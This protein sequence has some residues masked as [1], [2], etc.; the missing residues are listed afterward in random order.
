MNQHSLFLFTLPVRGR[1]GFASLISIMLLTC[2]IAGAGLVRAQQPAWSTTGGLSTARSL[3]TATPLTNGKV[4]VVGGINVINPCCTNTGNAELYDPATG[5]WSAAINPSTP[6]ANHVAVR[7]HNGKVLIASGNGSPFGNILDSAEIYDPVTGNWS[8]AG[9]L[10]VAR[11]SPRATLLADGR[12]LVTG[13]VAV[14]GGTAI[15]TNTAEVYDPATNVWTP[16][17]P[18]NSARVLHTVN[19]LPNGKAL[20]AGGSAASF[21]PILQRTTEIYDPATNNWTLTGELT[22]PRLTHTTILLSNGKV[23]V[24]GGSNDSSGTIIA[25]AELYDPA[26][27]QWSAINNMT[28]PRVIHT[29]TL[30]PNGK[31]LAVGGASANTGG[32]L[33]SSELYDPATGNWTVSADLGAGRQNHTATLLFNGMV[34]ATAGSGAGQLTSAELYHGGAS[35]IASISAASFT[36]GS[37]P[38]SI[39]AAFGG[40]NLATSTQ[41]AS[42]VPLPTTLAGVSVRVRDGAGVERLAPLFFVSPGQINYQVPP[43]TTAGQCLVTVVRDDNP[44]AVGVIEIVKVAPGLFSA[45]AS[46]QGVA[47]AVALRIKADGTQS[48]EPV[49]QFDQALNRFVALPVDLGAETDQV[50]LLLFGTGIKFHSGLSYVSSAIG[51]INSEVLYAGAAPGF[52]GLDQVNVRLSHSLAGRGEVDVV[53][54]VEGQIANK[55][56]VS[57][58]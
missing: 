54:T 36:L 45:N 31:V 50:F 37:A 47:A 2:L 42:S 34:L 39:V 27:G 52:A 40:V 8:P 51:G 19:L 6:R 25:N 55:V 20:V 46:G 38:E 9:N 24:T 29:L 53:L 12:V 57:I 3:H 14:V 1:S 58:R 5:Q 28:T 16:T 48:F 4:L 15:F 49:A 23:L 33:R 43:G 17:G 18:M 13:G 26:T 56:S 22:T 44:V 21:N 7:L 35:S 41:I 10:G 32:L 11:Q 30:L